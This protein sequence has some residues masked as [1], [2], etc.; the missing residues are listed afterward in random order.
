[1]STHD[2]LL[3]LNADKRIVIKNGGISKIIET[4]AKEKACI[5]KF[6]N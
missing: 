2:P 6:A 4:T 3:A 1:M 5:E